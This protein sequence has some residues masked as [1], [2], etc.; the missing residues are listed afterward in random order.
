MLLNMIEENG[1]RRKKY[2]PE[3]NKKKYIDKPDTILKKKNKKSEQL[4][5]SI[6]VYIYTVCV[7]YGH[8]LSSDSKRWILLS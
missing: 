6:Y 3:K 4:R 1:A 5:V 7:L 2:R 8:I